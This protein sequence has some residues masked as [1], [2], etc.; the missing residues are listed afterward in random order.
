MTSPSTILIAGAGLGGLAA[1]LGLANAGF[2]TV[3]FEAA[4]E[5][6]E[7]GAGLQLAPNAMRAL[8]SLHVTEALRPYAVAPAALRVM[9]ARSGSTIASI[10]LGEE[11]ERRYG[12]PYWVVHRADLQRV[13]A[14]AVAAKPEVVM[15]LGFTVRDFAARHGGVAIAGKT[16]SGVMASEQGD[17]LVGADG[18]WSAVRER[19]GHEANPQFQRRTAWRALVDADAVEP[20][21][22]EPL[23]HLW[24]GAGAHL[25]HY[26]VRGGTAVNIV[27]IV[28]DASATRGWAEPA[29]RDALLAQLARWTPR[30]R[31][32][33]A[34]PSAWQRWSLHDLPA[35]PRPGTGPVTLIGDAAH[36]MLPF[37]AQGAAMAIED[38]VVLADCTARGTTDLAAAFRDYER[39]R[40]ERVVRAVRESARMGAIYHLSTLAAIARN[41]VMRRAGGQRLG[42]R[43]DWLYRWPA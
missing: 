30:A 26:P 36:P 35:K 41:L 1:A 13:W 37:L 32:I 18:L 17:A 31:G 4:R 20:A 19:L 28:Q 10:P 16:R 42:A 43:Q 29:D 15:R 24:L 23:V 40:A 38:A 25:V 14:E 21:W 5:L 12:A 6:S 11:I 2:R 22:R 8:A 34:A 39:Q 3:V 33:L 9:N 7:V 27:A